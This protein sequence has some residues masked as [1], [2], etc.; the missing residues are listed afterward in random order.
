MKVCVDNKTKGVAIKGKLFDDIYACSCAR[1]YLTTVNDKLAQG[2]TVVS[3]LLMFLS[4]TQERNLPVLG[5][6]L[7]TKAF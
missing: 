3:K 4:T 5:I 1:R 7:Q 2:T 6:E